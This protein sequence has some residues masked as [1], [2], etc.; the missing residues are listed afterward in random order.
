MGYAVSNEA[1]QRKPQIASKNLDS[2][3]DCILHALGYQSMAV[4][5]TR[6]PDAVGWLKS[7]RGCLDEAIEMLEGQL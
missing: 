7:A 3:T 6:H 5:N 2:P 4:N 1:A